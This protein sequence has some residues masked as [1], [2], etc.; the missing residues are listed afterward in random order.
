MQFGR[1]DPVPESILTE[2]RNR[3]RKA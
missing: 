3:E 2:V 1:Y